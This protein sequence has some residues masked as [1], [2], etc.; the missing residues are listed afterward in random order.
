MGWYQ[1]AES[2]VIVAYDRSLGGAFVTGAQKLRVR[3]TFRVKF[4]L[5]GTV[6]DLDRAAGSGPAHKQEMRPAA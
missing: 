2:S 4:E 6:P 3:R 5:P 1:R